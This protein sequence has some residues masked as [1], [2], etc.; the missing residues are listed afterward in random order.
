[1]KIICRMRA[2]GRKEATLVCEVCEGEEER[3]G[4]IGERRVIAEGRR[5]SVREIVSVGRGGE[6]EKRILD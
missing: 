3:G 4:R 2:P 5:R 6:S 1:M